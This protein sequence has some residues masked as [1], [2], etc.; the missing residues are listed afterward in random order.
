MCLYLKTKKNEAISQN[1]NI[2]QIDKFGSVNLNWINI[3]SHSCHGFA[4]FANEASNETNWQKGV[5]RLENDIES[6]DSKKHGLLFQLNSIYWFCAFSLSFPSNK[7][8]KIT[9][10]YQIWTCN[11][12]VHREIGSAIKMICCAAVVEVCLFVTMCMRYQDMHPSSLTLSH[13]YRTRATI[14]F[15]IERNWKY[16]HISQLVNACEC[17]NRCTKWWST[18]R[19]NRL[20]HHS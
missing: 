20:K 15:G 14:N 11:A 5:E 17:V 3:C 13:A 18:K 19:I 7:N 8:R 6:T 2:W 1:V 16:A 10:M 9:A 12:W 4:M